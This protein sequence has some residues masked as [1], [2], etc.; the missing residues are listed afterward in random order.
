M[1][2][3][4]LKVYLE[5]LRKESTE[6]MLHENQQAIILHYLNNDISIC[7][8]GIIESLIILS[9]SELNEEQT[10][11]LELMKMSVNNLQDFINE[12]AS[13]FFDSEQIK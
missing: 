12:L 9:N 1:R 3:T 8:N 4:I 5:E 11:L 13:S 6:L 10:K 2:N 7:L